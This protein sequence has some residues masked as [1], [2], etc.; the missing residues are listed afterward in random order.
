MAEELGRLLNPGALDVDVPDQRVLRAWD[1]TEN[2]ADRLLQQ[3][4]GRDVDDW[5]IGVPA[6]TAGR[7]AELVSPKSNRANAEPGRAGLS[8]PLIPRICEYR[9]ATK[10]Y[11]LQ[12]QHVR[13]LIA[14]TIPAD[15]DAPNQR[16]LRA[17]GIAPE[18]AHEIRRLPQVIHR[19][20]SGGSI[21]PAE[22]IDIEKILE[23]LSPQRPRF[24][25]R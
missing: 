5:A 17:L 22:E 2:A 7:R 4:R 25:L 10:A 16:V 11:A 14:R 12:R 24:N 8:P 18:N 3:S 6:R 13:A 23:R 9:R 19:V 15:V 21:G 20:C 1:S